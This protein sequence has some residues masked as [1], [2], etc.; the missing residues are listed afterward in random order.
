MCLDLANL[1]FLDTFNTGPF[2]AVSCYI[3]GEQKIFNM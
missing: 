1:H 2:Y 3:A